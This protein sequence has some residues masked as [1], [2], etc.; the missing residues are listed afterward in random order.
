MTLK[1]ETMNIGNII[2]FLSQATQSCHP[3]L[4]SGSLR[5]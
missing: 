5:C 2:A 3:E 1:H 4:V